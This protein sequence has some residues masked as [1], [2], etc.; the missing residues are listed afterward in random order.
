[1]DFFSQ[2]VLRD[3]SVAYRVIEGQALVVATSDDED[4]KLLML[5]PTGTRVW[6]MAD[7][8]EIEAIVN[9]ICAS[10][11]VKREQAEADVTAFVCE[12]VSR[13]LLTIGGTETRTG[14]SKCPIGPR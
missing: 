6:E 13:G 14:N 1:M 2:H 3:P 12:F 5:N 11:E 8:R 10:F 7:G 9:E 4:N